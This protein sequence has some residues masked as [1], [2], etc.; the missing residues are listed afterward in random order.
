[1][2]ENVAAWK[3]VTPNRLRL[4]CVMLYV[5]GYSAAFATFMKSAMSE[6]IKSLAI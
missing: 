4:L 1:M 3:L 6:G 2:Y 5:F